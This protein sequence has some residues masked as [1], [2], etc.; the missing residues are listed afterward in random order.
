MI[1]FKRFS[2]RATIA[3]KSWGKPPFFARQIIRKKFMLMT[4]KRVT[5]LGIYKQFTY[6]VLTNKFGSSGLQIPKILKNILHIIHNNDAGQILFYIYYMC[7]A[8][9]YNCNHLFA[10]FS[11]YT[12]Q[13]LISGVHMY[14]MKLIFQRN[15]ILLG[16]CRKTQS[17]PSIRFLM[18]TQT[19]AF[20][21]EI[22]QYLVITLGNYLT[23]DFHLGKRKNFKGFIQTICFITNSEFQNMQ[24]LNL[25]K[26]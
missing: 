1:S 22:I 17:C 18:L 26:D 2:K 3:C 25:V 15:L 5:G 14:M 8:I 11:D 24:M 21:R 12:L 9:M 6:M 4:L 16:I 19:W 23:L 10:L 13:K 20:V 7:T